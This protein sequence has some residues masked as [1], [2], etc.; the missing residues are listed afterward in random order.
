MGTGEASAKITDKFGKQFS[1]KKK[2]F[3]LT[4]VKF[5]SCS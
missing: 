4:A 3:I 1:K 2:Y 5:D